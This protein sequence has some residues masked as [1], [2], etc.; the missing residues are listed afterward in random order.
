VKDKKKIV[1]IKGLEDHY[2]LMERIGEL[3]DKYA[4]YLILIVVRTIT[5]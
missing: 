4:E 1:V 3:L 5:D 2:L